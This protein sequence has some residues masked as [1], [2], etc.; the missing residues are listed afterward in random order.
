MISSTKLI[1]LGYEK[2][3]LFEWTKG[4]KKITFDGCN[5]KLNEKVI[6]KIEEIKKHDSISR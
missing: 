2:T 3:G 1:K 4:D 6:S 5:W